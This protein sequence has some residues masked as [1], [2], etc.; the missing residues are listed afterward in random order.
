MDRLLALLAVVTAAGFAAPAHA[1]PGANDADPGF[2]A[3]LRNAGITYTSP[4][5]AIDAAHAVCDL[6][7]NGQSGLQVITSLQNANPE[8]T[9][10]GAATFARLA[11]NSYCPQQLVPSNKK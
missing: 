8:F 2:L 11:A 6:A 7:G 10:D 4:E 1:D 3:S 9:M 5:Q